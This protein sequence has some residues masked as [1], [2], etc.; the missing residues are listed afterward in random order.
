MCGDDCRYELTAPG[1]QYFGCSVGGVTTPGGASIGSHCSA[2]M[3]L[4]VNV[5]L[6]SVPAPT[7]EAAGQLAEPA[8][9]AASSPTAA[10]ILTAEQQG[11]RCLPAQTV[12]GTDMWFVHCVTATIPL[13]PG[14]VSLQRTPPCTLPFWGLH[15]C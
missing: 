9:Q 6:A 3:L 15:S 14:D 12:P 11:T 1:T 4:T 10:P 2:G 8:A 5:A 7:E 13:R